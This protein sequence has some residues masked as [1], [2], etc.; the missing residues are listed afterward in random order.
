MSKL[1][2]FQYLLCALLL[3][4]GGDNG[5]QDNNDPGD[6]SGSCS[7]TVTLYPAGFSGSYWTN[8]GTSSSVPHVDCIGDD[9]CLVEIDQPSPDEEYEF[10]FES[11]GYLFAT[12]SVFGNS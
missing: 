2:I 6:N 7:A 3:G 10:D 8:R 9:S 5:T 11:D 4:C 1:R 12:K